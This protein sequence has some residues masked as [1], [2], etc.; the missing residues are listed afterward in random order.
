MFLQRIR[1][2]RGNQNLLAGRASQMMLTR[3]PAQISGIPPN[4][5]RS[6][7]VLEC[8]ARDFFPTFRTDGR[9]RF[10]PKVAGN[11][12]YGLSGQAKAAIGYRGTVQGALQK[13][14]DADFEEELKQVGF[15][16][17]ADVCTGI[18]PIHTR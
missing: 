2:P 1:P 18:F 5:T 3:R 6:A 12:W 13:M 17:T 7:T 8:R 4:R 15:P 14:R 9:G 16:S 10:S 11:L